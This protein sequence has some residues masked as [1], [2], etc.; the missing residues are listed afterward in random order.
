MSIRSAVL[1]KESSEKY[2]KRRKNLIFDAAPDLIGAVFL[3]ESLVKHYKQ[4]TA[5]KFA[6]SLA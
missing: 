1:R 4:K 6:E 5:Y 2:N 3:N